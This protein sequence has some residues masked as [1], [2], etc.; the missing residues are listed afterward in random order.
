MKKLFFVCSWNKRK[1][2]TWSGI[3]WGLYK[4][5][6]KYYDIQ[7]VDIMSVSESVISKSIKEDFEDKGGYNIIQNVIDVIWVD[8]PVS[9]EDYQWIKEKCMRL[10]G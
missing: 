1:E 2:L 4:S 6:K 7:D 8:A 10:L 9:E 5:L 3:C